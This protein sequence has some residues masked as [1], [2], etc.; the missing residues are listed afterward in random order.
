MGKL[1]YSSSRPC[2]FQSLRLE[3]PLCTLARNPRQQLPLEISVY[4]PPFYF[5]SFSPASQYFTLGH[6][7]LP[8]CFASLADTIQGVFSR[9]LNWPL[10]CTSATFGLF[11]QLPICSLGKRSCSTYFVSYLC[12]QHILGL[13]LLCKIMKSLCPIARFSYNLGT[14]CILINI[15]PRTNQE[16]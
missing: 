3:L 2:C 8:W 10:Q 14:K 9:S 15:F 5:P 4:W 13:S 1:S 12:A 11:W 6:L 7:P 16:A